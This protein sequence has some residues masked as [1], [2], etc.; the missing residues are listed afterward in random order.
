MTNGTVGTTVTGVD[1]PMITVKYKDGE[2][3][4]VVPPDVPIVRYVIGDLERYQTRRAHSL[5]SRPLKQPDGSFDVNRINVGRDG[6]IPAIIFGLPL[7]ALACSR[8]LARCLL[9]VG[10]AIASKEGVP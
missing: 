5:S 10:I 9:V 6:A 7:T 2:Q 8:V 3:K 4:I 1:G